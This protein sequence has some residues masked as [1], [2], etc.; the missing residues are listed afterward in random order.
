MLERVSAIGAQLGSPG[1]P[2]AVGLVSLVNDL[3][4]SVSLVPTKEAQVRP[5]GSMGA[6]FH[7]RR[8]VQ[9]ISPARLAEVLER[10]ASDLSR[11][12]DPMTE[13]WLAAIGYGPGQPLAG[14]LARLALLALTDGFRAI[15]AAD[16]DLAAIMA[17]PLLVEA[18]LA[19]SGS[20]EQYF[21]NTCSAAALNQE[22]RSK[23]PTIAW[24]A[25]LGPA[26]RRPC[27][28]AARPWIDRL[29][30]ARPD[31]SAVAVQVS[32][33]SAT[34]PGRGLPRRP[35]SSMPSRPRWRPL[36]PGPARTRRPGCGGYPAV[37]PD[38]AEAY[39]GDHARWRL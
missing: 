23:V 3:L 17:S 22:V 5:F 15:L 16:V 20:E 34:S 21:L 7:D 2:I 30:P 28:D 38:D 4:L 24:S 36:S 13:P 19:S 1:S 25:G 9:P 27:P 6:T 26:P 11:G 10:I 18:L 32:G 39:G 14:R 8:S 29:E 35:L 31:G 37:E 12:V 33:R